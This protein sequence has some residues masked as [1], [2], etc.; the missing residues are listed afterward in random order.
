MPRSKL[1]SSNTITICG[2]LRRASQAPASP[3]A[4]RCQEA[5]PA[6]NTPRTTRSTAAT[7]PQRQRRR[8]HR[9]PQR[10]KPEEV[11]EA[12]GENEA[13]LCFPFV[14]G[15]DQQAKRSEMDGRKQ[16]HLADVLRI[17]S[18]EA[19]FHERDGGRHGSKRRG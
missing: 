18:H 8:R 3:R 2:S 15:P 10:G 14:L 13:R 7:A 1:D 17:G 6:S 12:P 5:A 19:L 9:T 4:N 16:R 11:Q